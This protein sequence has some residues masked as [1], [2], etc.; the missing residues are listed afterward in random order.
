[1]AKLGELIGLMQGSQSGSDSTLTV[2]EI[3]ANAM[4]GRNSCQARKDVE[5]SNSKVNDGIATKIAKLKSELN[6][7]S[8]PLFVKENST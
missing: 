5:N 4:G 2:S 8:L 3:N 7:S 6:I 1:M